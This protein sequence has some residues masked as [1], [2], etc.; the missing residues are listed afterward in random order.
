MQSGIDVVVVVDEV[1]VVELVLLVDGAVEV[2]NVVDGGKVHVVVG[3]NVHVVVGGNVHVLV[4]GK[5]HVVVVVVNVVDGGSV[6]VLVGGN[7]HV[8]VGGNVHVVVV[9]VNVVVGGSVHVVDGR[10]DVVNVELLGT[11]VAITMPRSSST[12]PG[13]AH[14]DAIGS[15]NPMQS[16]ARSIIDVLPIARS[17]EAIRSMRSR[18]WVLI[19]C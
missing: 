6:H 19:E 17:F 10:V 7:V 18:E 2:V 16:T 14:A 12:R 9:V 8:V 5:V 1:V 4:D 13:A 3:G 15:R 11:V